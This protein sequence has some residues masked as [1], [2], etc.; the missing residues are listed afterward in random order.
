MN[1]DETAVYEHKTK[2][3]RK[4]DTNDIFVKFVSYNIPF[5]SG[6]AKDRWNIGQERCP[7]KQYREVDRNEIEKSLISNIWK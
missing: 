7:E 5:I 4:E 1:N 3:R 2:Y 6:H